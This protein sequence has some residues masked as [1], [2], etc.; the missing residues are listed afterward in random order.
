MELNCALCEAHTFK[1]NAIF[2][3]MIKFHGKSF[4]SEKAIRRVTAVVSTNLSAVLG[5]KLFY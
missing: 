1:A 3:F 5:V 2:S 4:F